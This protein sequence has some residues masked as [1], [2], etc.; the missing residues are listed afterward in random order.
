VLYH[1]HQATATLL[2]V[3]IALFNLLVSGTNAFFKAA[4]GLTVKLTTDN[5]QKSLTAI[6]DI[7][8]L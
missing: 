1:S 6:I 7:V 2:E 5:Y 3:S 4:P 8:V